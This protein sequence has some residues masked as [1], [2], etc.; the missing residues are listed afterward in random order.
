MIFIFVSEFE[1]SDN[2]D[3]SLGRTGKL[4]LLK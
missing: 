2:D 4:M 3:K 1:E